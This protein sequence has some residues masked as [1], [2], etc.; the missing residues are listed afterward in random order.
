MT[1]ER[2]EIEATRGSARVGSLPTPHG[3]V[4]TPAFC[5]RADEGIVPGLGPDEVRQ[6][7]VALLAASGLDLPL[8]PGIE[9][10]Q[11]L[12][13]IHRFVGWPGPLLVDAGTQR[14]CELDAAGGIHGRLER[15]DADGVSYASP[16]D[17]SVRRITPASSVEAL[18]ALGADIAVPLYDP[19]RTL[20]TQN[21]RGEVR[22]L[23]ALWAAAAFRSRTGNTGLML[24]GGVQ[25]VRN[26]DE[27]AWYAAKLPLD[28]YAFL[29][30]SRTPRFGPLLEILPA[31]TVRYLATAGGPD[32]LAIALAAGF[33]LVS[34]DAPWR[35]AREGLAYTERGT[36]SLKGP[37]IV[38]ERGPIEADCLCYTCQALER[39]YVRHLFGTH[40]M[41]GPRLVSVHNLAFVARLFARFRTDLLRA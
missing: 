27:A 36:V 11:R 7:G 26:R 6:A 12:A 10:I 30:V 15:V 5:P 1:S 25:D 29:A 34:S 2:F 20:G 14:L 41:L 32:E 22:G 23:S 33:D 9:S 18:E 35:D 19:G 31:A 8:R 38:A 28:G 37:P 16:V 13:G 3:T 40:E 21:R 4:L 24:V 17:G 39:P